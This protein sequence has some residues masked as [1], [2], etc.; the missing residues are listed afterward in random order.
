MD[1]KNL[2]FAM[3]IIGSL[4][5]AGLA[6]GAV[7]NEI[8]YDPEGADN[9]Y[10]WIEVYNTGNEEVDLSLYRINRAGTRHIIYE[11]NGSM[12]LQPG[13]Y[14]VIAQNPGLFLETY[15]DFNGT[16]MRS[17][18]TLRNTEESVC[19]DKNEVSLDCVNYHF[20][21]GGAD[22]GMTIEK[23]DP[24][25]ENTADN[26]MESKEIGGTPGR[27]NSVS[28]ELVE[29]TMKIMLSASILATGPN[30]ESIAFSSDYFPEREGVQ[31]MPVPGGQSEVFFGSVVGH[32]QSTDKIENVFAEV[33]GK[34]ILLEKTEEINET[35]AVFSGSFLMDYY[36]APGVYGVIVIA[37]D[38]YSY[39]EYLESEFEYLEVLALEISEPYA[40]FGDIVPGE[41]KDADTIPVIRNIGNSF[42]DIEMRASSLEGS[43]GVI[44]PES[45]YYSLGNSEFR[46]FSYDPATEYIN[47]GYGASSSLD[48][49]IRLAP[50]FGT[51]EGEYSGYV[52]VTAVAG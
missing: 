3:I 12:V 9:G 19:L 39:T 24:R 29:G 43:E 15:P 22:N 42:A 27:L 20:S 41:A 32:P 5:A 2:F 7:I 13:S 26:W 4:A 47:L 14:A 8:M 50:P 18:F 30:V 31:V 45:I 52:S 6:N 37:E 1:K 23:I 10:E 40:S 36:D 46:S 51:P 49:R 34:A 11:A 21:W 35:H 44:G 16:L 38:I 48:M 33:N 25:G 17:A 28:K